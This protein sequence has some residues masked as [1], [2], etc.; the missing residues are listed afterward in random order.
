MKEILWLIPLFPFLGFLFLLLFGGFLSRVQIIAVGT[1]TIVL[2]AVVTLLLGV[3][4]YQYPIHNNFFKLHLWN[5]IQ[6]G[7]FKPEFSFRLDALSLLMISVVTFVGSL[8][9]FYASEFMEEYG[10]ERRFFASMNLFITNMLILVLADNLLLLYLGWEGVGL[11]S[12]LLIGFWYKDPS[13]G[14]SARK[15]FIVT[16]IGDTALAVGLFLIFSQLGTLNIS[17][18]LLVAPTKWPVGSGVAT[19]AAL[20]L[21][22]GAAGKSAQFPLHTWLPDAMVGPTPVSA[23]IHAATMVTAGVYLIA[24]TNVLFSLAPLAQ[25]C[26]ATIGAITLLLAGMSALNQRDLKRVLAYSTISQIGYM[27]LALGVG[28]YTAAM[29]H[30]MTHAFFK[31]LLFLGA[32]V[33]GHCLHHEH[34]MFKMGGLHK[35]MP[36]TFW[37]FLIGSISLAALPL[38]S[39]GFYSKDLILWESWASEKGSPILWA[40]G[41]VGAFIT[42]LYTF[43]MIFITFFGRPHHEPDKAPGLRMHLPLIFLAILAVISGFVETPHTLGH[44]TVF[45]NWMHT[46][47]PPTP[48]RSLNPHTELIFQFIAA[49]VTL[50]GVFLAYHFYYKKTVKDSCFNSSSSIAPLCRF[51]YRGWGLDW[52]YDK[53][54]VRPYIWLAHINKNDFIDFF[55]TGFA[56]TV[57]FTHVIFSKT[58]TGRVKNYAT[59]IAVGTIIIIGIVVVS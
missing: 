35:S 3:E 22:G 43:R 13:N 28:A 51:W 38:I 30:F 31:A 27:F 36:I 33:I 42:A 44:V 40:A 4:F 37:T 15:A 9:A 16:R 8:I 48:L 50:F 20:L 49:G 52:L 21:L 11:C 25:G 39:A 18:I 5:W 32:G 59:G 19:A 57:R 26:V 7:S 56:Q 12:Y 45:S 53:L 17:E 58:Q 2:S 34:D 55:Y 24:R 10:E 23:L 29:F 46:I 1:G 6:V 41:L 14:R 47:L 54:F